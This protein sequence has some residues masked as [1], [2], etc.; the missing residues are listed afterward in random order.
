MK[1]HYQLGMAS[2]A[3]FLFCGQASATLSYSTQGV[4]GTVDTGTQ[5]V[6]SGHDTMEDDWANYL[7]DLGV[8]VSTTHDADGNSVT[9]DYQTNDTYDY[10]GDLTYAFKND[11]G[12]NLNGQDYEYV[13]AKYDGQNAGYVLFN[14]ADWFAGTGSYMIPQYPA[15]FWTTSTGQWA[16]SHWVGYNRTQVPEPATLLLL[17]LGLA[18]IG[19]AYRKR[20]C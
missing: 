1:L 6:G 16:V 20:A 12:T 9:E 2:L 11:N 18:A 5:S 17:G 13:F 15:N 3:M 7:L 10:S 19:F 8:G 4:V 14:M